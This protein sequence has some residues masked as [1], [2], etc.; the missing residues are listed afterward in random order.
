MRFR[1]DY[2]VVAL[3]NFKTPNQTSFHAHRI[4]EI[5]TFDATN[6]PLQAAMV[7]SMIEVSAPMKDG[8]DI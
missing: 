2:L 1:G 8:E 3:E 4:R 6:F 5:V 7:E